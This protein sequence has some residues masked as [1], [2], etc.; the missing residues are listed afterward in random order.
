MSM[1]VAILAG[2]LATRLGTLAEHIPKSLLEVA[3]K[4]FIEHQLVLLSHAGISDVVLCVG[5]LGAM[6][7]ENL[8]DGAR[9]GVRIRYSDD[10]DTR[11]GTGGAVRNALPL[12]GDAF[13]VLYGDSYLDCDYRAIETSYERLGLPALMT[14]FRNEGAFDTSNVEYADRKILRYDKKVRTPG[15]Q[16]IDY[17]LGIFKADIFRRYTDAL[18]FDLADVYTDLV[19]DSRLAAYEVGTRFYEIGSEKGLAETRAVIE[20]KLRK[21]LGI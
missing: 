5:H 3:G 16:H 2:G 4:P 10:G 11:R 21:P 12:L 13:F 20:E 6:I 14:V 19:R 8:G 1:P 9:L 7:Q 17:G 18:A 15:M